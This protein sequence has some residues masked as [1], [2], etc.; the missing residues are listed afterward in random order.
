MNALRLFG[1]RLIAYGPAILILLGALIAT[2]CDF[3]QPYDPGYP[4]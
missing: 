4:R 3:S 2:F 1:T